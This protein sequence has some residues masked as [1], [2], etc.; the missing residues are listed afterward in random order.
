MPR[1]GVAGFVEGFRGVDE[2]SGQGRQAVDAD[3]PLFRPDSST[4]AAW[5]AGYRV[6]SLRPDRCFILP[7]RLVDVLQRVSR[8]PA[9]DVAALTPRLWKA[10]FAADPLR[11]DV[12][13]AMHD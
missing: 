6:G 7:M 12:M 8:H 3:D 1:W 11:S 10:R 4:A 13:Q 2:C 5:R 9:K